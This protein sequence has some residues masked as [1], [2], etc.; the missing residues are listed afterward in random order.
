MS[1]FLTKSKDMYFEDPNK[2]PHFA[3]VLEVIQE[4][5][6]IKNYYET[7]LFNIEEILS[8]LEMGEYLRGNQLKDDFLKYIID[9]IVHFTPEISEWPPRGIP[10]NWFDFLF[11]KNPLWETY[12]RFIGNLCHLRFKPS[13]SGFDNSYSGITCEPITDA[14]AQYSIITLNYDLVLESI[15]EFVKDKYANVNANLSI[16]KLHGSVDTGVIVPP[17]WSKGVNKEIVPAWKQAFQF[18]AEA[19][20]IRIVG[21]SLPTADAYVKYLLKSAVAKAPHLKRIDIICMDDKGQT[22]RQRY[23]QFISFAYYRFANASVAEYLDIIKS[24]NRESDG[25]V[26]LGQLER[27]H[28]SFFRKYS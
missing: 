10:G 9:V 12:G 7:D 19:N 13:K 20:H 15:V 14:N 18:L 4:M 24:N 3:R 6:V 28:E 21:Y 5:S 27:A 16:A 23:D 22:V 17:T 25:T 26:I 2:Y 1:N 11:G 8:I